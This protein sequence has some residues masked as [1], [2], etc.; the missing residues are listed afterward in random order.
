MQNNQPHPGYELVSLC[1]F[2][3]SILPY[4]VS[5]VLHN[6]V[7]PTVLWV[8]EGRFPVKKCLTINS[9]LLHLGYLHF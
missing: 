9:A 4:Q 5:R 2:P 1:L 6:K 8:M 7:M 3:N